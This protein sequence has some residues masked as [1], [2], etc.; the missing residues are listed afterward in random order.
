MFPRLD[1]DASSLVSIRSYYEVRALQAA[2]YGW[3]WSK[4]L[5]PVHELEDTK[6]T[7]QPLPTVVSLQSNTEDTAKDADKSAPSPLSCCY[8]TSF[9]SPS[10]SVHYSF[11]IPVHFRRQGVFSRLIELRRSLYTQQPVVTIQECNLASL[12]SKHGLPVISLDGDLRIHASPAYALISSQYGS[13]R[14]RRTNIFYMHHIDEG[15]LVMN[16]RGCS[17]LAQQAYAIHPLLQGDAELLEFEAWIEKH[18]IHPKVFI[19][20]ME[21]RRVANVYLSPKTVDE[22]DVFELS[23]LQEVNEMLVADKV[24]NFKDFLRCHAG[25]H[26]ERERLDLYF[27]NWLKRLG[28]SMHQFYSYKQKLEEITQ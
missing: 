18:H 6:D 20:A 9:I 22:S 7:E 21:Y 28:V 26:P 13:K 1:A 14:A 4:T 19:L 2:Y 23:C 16:W 17:E 11:F 3:R 5:E 25:S 15:L 24:Q 12:L 8:E 27:R 10:G